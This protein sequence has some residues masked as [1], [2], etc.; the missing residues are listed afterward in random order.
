MG[1]ESKV[2]HQVELAQ[3]V[4]AFATSSTAHK[5]LKLQYDIVIIDSPQFLSM[6]N[7][8]SGSG[9]ADNRGV[10]RVLISQSKQTAILFSSGTTG[11]VKGVLLTHVI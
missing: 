9:N 6:T 4:I 7:G 2:A 3:P 11:R 1:S 10:R 8:T 5:I